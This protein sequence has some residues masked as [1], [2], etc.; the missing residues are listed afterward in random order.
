MELTHEP[1]LYSRPQKDLIRRLKRKPY[2]LGG[3][4][5]ITALCRMKGL[6]LPCPVFMWILLALSVT[7]PGMNAC[8]SARRSATLKWVE[9]LTWLFTFWS[10]CFWECEVRDSK[11]PCLLLWRPPLR[12]RA[13]AT[14]TS[15]FWSSGQMQFMHGFPGDIRPF[16]CYHIVH[17][18][19]WIFSLLTFPLIKQLLT[20]H[21]GSF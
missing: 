8:F 5:V 16:I 4:A 12:L 9:I 15:L 17:I 11:C 21:Y 20:T 3:S 14:G 7:V 2:W 19:S 6:K 1:K 13:G 18:L 10:F